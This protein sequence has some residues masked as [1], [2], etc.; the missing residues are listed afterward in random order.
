MFGVFTDEG[1]VADGFYTK[2]EA[3]IWMAANCEA[4]EARVA[5]IC[6]DHPEHERATCQPCNDGDE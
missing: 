5:E 6:E 2:E 4:G 3:D 1:A